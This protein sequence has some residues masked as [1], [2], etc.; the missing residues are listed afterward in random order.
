MLKLDVS[1]E[2]LSLQ[3]LLIGDCFEPSILN[4]DKNEAFSTI[5]SSNL[6][7]QFLTVEKF[8]EQLIDDPRVLS[9]LVIDKNS[10]L[11]LAINSPQQKSVFIIA[12]NENCEANVYINSYPSAKSLLKAIN[13]GFDF[14]LN[15]YQIDKLNKDI[16]IVSQERKELSN[17]GIAMSAEK[18]LYKLLTMVLEEGRK[19]GN[20]EA[21]SLY[22]VINAKSENPELLFKL[23]QNSKMKFDFKEMNNKLRH[24]S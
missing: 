7:V 24:P 5:N 22:L 9:V 6:Q 3:I 15:R 16:N 4:L 8:S 20:C 2:K 18:N 17:I 12:C 1:Q 23:T 13:M 14:L 11:S 21:A 19:F 10:S